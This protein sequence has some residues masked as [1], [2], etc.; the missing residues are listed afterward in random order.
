[1]IQATNAPACQVVGFSLDGT[2]R[3]PQ[4]LP[5][6]AASICRHCPPGGRIVT[7][8]GGDLPGGRSALSPSIWSMTA[9]ARTGST[10]P[11]F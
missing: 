3:N 4:G 1:M 11:R 5:S 9:L 2:T 7:R 10:Q 6:P 8:P